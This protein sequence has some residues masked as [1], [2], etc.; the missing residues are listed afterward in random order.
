MRTFLQKLVK[1]LSRPNSKSSSP[2]HFFLT[3]LYAQA[4]EDFYFFQVGANDG[5]SN[6]PIHSFVSMYRPSGLL[7]E[8]QSDA[9]ARLQVTYPAKSFPDLKLVNAAIA[10]SNSTVTLYRIRPDFEKTYRQFYKSTA[11]ASGISSLDFNHVRSFLLKAMPGFFAH[12]DVKNY[13]DAISVPGVTV[14]TLLKE[15]N[16]H[17]IHFVQID[18]E[19]FDAKIVSMLLES[20]L[21]TMPEL[22]H[23]ESKNIAK[24]EK[25][26]LFNRLFKDG[27]KIHNAGGDT[28]AERLHRL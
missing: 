17:R 11:N 9:F 23:F 21:C 27:Y 25:N 26:I 4:R 15:N 28:V 5:R 20:Q 1:K 18:A 12:N 14:N 10:P 19:G 22:I 2:L 3:Q 16:V 7:V 6:D 8:P 24:E 13:I